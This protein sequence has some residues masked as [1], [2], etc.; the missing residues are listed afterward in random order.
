VLR[1]GDLVVGQVRR[2][3]HHEHRRYAALTGNARRLRSQRC[4]TM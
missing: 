3:L 4:S 1:G 2:S